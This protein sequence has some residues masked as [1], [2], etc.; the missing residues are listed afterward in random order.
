MD[1]PEKITSSTLSEL[2]LKYKVCAR[3]LKIWIAPFKEYIGKPTGYIYKPD[4]VR[5]IIE[6]IGEW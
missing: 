3:T 2:A 6:K 1:S 5:K 4:Q